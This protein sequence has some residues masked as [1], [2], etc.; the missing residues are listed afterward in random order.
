MKRRGTARWIGI[1]FIA[2]LG[3]L[4]VLHFTLTATLVQRSMI[5]R[6]HEAGFHN[7]SVAVDSVEISRVHLTNLAMGRQNDL[8][9]GAMSMASDGVLVLGG[10][11]N[12]IE[13]RDAELKLRIRA[14]R[15]D[16]SN[17]WQPSAGS[18]YG[19]PFKRIDVHDSTLDI[20]LEGRPVQLPVHG[21][22][23]HDGGNR[24]LI[25]L[26]ASMLNIPV[27]ITG[28]FDVAT[29]ESEI[30]TGLFGRF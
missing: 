13:V 1:G 9:V 16:W 7:V 15:L 10:A 4:L 8:R 24:L 26:K 21:Q 22:I 2:L 14:G 25:E 27:P 12:T 28:W 5:A 18:G 6:L 23:L 20:D 30:R 3:V 19:V 29:G 11:I 17:L